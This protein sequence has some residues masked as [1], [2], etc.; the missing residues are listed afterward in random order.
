MTETS[1]SA[2]IAAA[3]ADEALSPGAPETTLPPATVD[4]LHLPEPKQSN[5]GSSSKPNYAPNGKS[6]AERSKTDLVMKKLRSARGV[7]VA[8]IM[9]ATSWQRHSVRGFLSAVVKKKFS[10]NL[11]SE[12]GK[13][14]QRRYRVADSTPGQTG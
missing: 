13:D 3:F 14:G 9:D 6:L 11:V 12:V 8:Q 2:V 4:P 7:T 1:I 5:S 10:L